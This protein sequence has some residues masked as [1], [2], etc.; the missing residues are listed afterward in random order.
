MNIFELFFFVLAIVCA[1][2]GAIYG[3]HWGITAS[4]AGA[5]VGLLTPFVLSQL[6]VMID[7]IRYSKTGQGRRRAIA[8][9]HFDKT[10]REKRIKSWR[11][12]PQ[13]AFDGSTIVTIFYG[14]SKPPRRA[15]YRFASDSE[16][17]QFLQGD[18]ILK[19]IQPSKMR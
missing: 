12:R 17:P 18:E 15:F 4:I 3:K 6:V 14:Q 1:V 10:T 11:A 19:Y 8:E 5:F 2:T 13:K 16:E 7:E 9:S